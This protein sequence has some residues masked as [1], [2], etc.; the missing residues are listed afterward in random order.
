[1]RAADG[2]GSLWFLLLRQSRQLFALAPVQ[3][4]APN[5]VWKILLV[6]TQCFDLKFKF[7][8]SIK[9]QLVFHLHLWKMISFNFVFILNSV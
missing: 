9:I 5:I 3:V 7:S 1:M 6:F 4:R 8:F 2:Q